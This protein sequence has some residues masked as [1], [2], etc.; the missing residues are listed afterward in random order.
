MGL[1]PSKLEHENKKCTVFFHFSV[2]KNILPEGEGKLKILT[3]FGSTK[4][5]N[6]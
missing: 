6:E 5:Y 3:A 4:E 1:L 2:K